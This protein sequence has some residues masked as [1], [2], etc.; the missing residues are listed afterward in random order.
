MTPESVAAKKYD[1]DRQ[2]DCP[3]ADAERNLASRWIGEPH[4]FPDINRKD[5][6]E[7][8]REIKKV[9]VHVLH[10]QGERA[11]AEIR[12]ARFAH[13]ASGRIGPETLVLGAAAA[14]TGPTN[15]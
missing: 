15:T 4:R 6:D 7:A 10:D 13:S 12:I 9:T 14:I 3:D 11:L 5:D 1:V 8:E 2:N